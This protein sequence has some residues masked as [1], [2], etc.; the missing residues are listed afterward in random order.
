[1]SG[2]LFI[3]LHALKL[4]PPVLM[5]LLILASALICVTACSAPH[6]IMLETYKKNETL[7]EYKEILI[8]GEGGMQ[9]KMYLQNLTNELGKQLLKKNIQCHYVYLGDPRKVNTNEAFESAKAGQYDAVIRMIPQV[10]E[11]ITHKYIP[12]NAAPNASVID[13]R[14]LNEHI[15]DFNLTLKEKTD[16]IIWEGRLKTDIDPVAKNIYKGISKR[17][18]AVL[19]ENLIVPAK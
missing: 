1:M 2:H 13:T 6:K 7:K 5:R 15:N 17:V 9:S 14:Y 10:T 11:E 3:Y 18:L 12:Y 4:I 16:V 19:A 8:T